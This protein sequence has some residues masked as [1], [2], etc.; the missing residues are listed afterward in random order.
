MNQHDREAI[1]ANGQHPIYGL[2]SVTIAVIAG[3]PIFKENRR[4]GY[5]EPNEGRSG[6]IRVAQKGVDRAERSVPCRQKHPITIRPVLK[7]GDI[8]QTYSLHVKHFAGF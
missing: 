5:N 6:K 2:K 4:D 3:V 1:Q 7:F 8:F